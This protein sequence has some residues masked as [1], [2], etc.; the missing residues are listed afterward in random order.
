MRN[1]HLMIISIYP[2]MQALPSKP[3]GLQRK[4]DM[5]TVS[6]YTP[7]TVRAPRAAAWAAF[8]FTRFLGWFERGAA[9]RLERR[10]QADRAAEAAAVRE[11]AQRF[12][13]HDPRFA[14]DLMAAADRHE[15][16][17]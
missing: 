16:G 5:V 1:I 11:Y 10:E 17:E 4:S 13:S 14:A 8:L 2:N 6:V 3:G 15:R 7:V 9:Q 12:A